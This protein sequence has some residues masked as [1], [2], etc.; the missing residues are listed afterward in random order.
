MSTYLRTKGSLVRVSS[1][2]GAKAVLQIMDDHNTEV[3]WT[4]NYNHQKIG[5]F[6]NRTKYH[7]IIG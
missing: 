7:W 1:L 2:P 6:N 3:V 5:C 4:S